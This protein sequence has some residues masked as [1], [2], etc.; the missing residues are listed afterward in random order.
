MIPFTFL[1]SLQKETKRRRINRPAIT[2]TTVA[3]IT[4]SDALPL[5]FWFEIQHLPSEIQRSVAAGKAFGQL[6]GK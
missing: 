4:E 2:G 5:V 1:L 6:I 3:S